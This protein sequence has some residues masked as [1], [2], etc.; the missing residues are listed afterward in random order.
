[1][2]R[3]EN[4]ASDRFSFGWLKTG[5]KKR[6]I[7]GYH[8]ENIDSKQPVVIAVGST[9]VGNVTAP[10]ITV[11][12]QLFGTAVASRV[13]I[14]AQ[15]QVWGDVYAAELN[16]ESGGKL[17]GWFTTIHADGI[18]NLGIDV[19]PQ[20]VIKDGSEENEMIHLTQRDPD[21]IQA[22]RLLQRE[23][24]VAL[25]A[26]AELEQTFDQ[27]V[28]EVIGQA[29]TEVQTLRNK[30]EA[31]Q[32]Q[33]E[34]LESRVAL[35]TLTQHTQEEQLKQQAEEL[36]VARDLLVERQQTIDVLQ[37]N[38]DGVDATNDQFQDQL[39]E[40]RQEL[41][42]SKEEIRKRG[43][44][45]RG[46]ESA[47]QGSLQHTSEQEESLVRWQELAEA[48]ELHVK[49]LEGELDS[50]RLE[51]VERTSRV[52]DWQGELEPDQEMSIF[53]D[54]NA[55][56]IS[57]LA[58]LQEEA[59]E[60]SMQL[61]WYKA[62]LETS[63]LE[64]ESY[65]Q[66]ALGQNKLLT[67]LQTEFDAQ[68]LQT[69]K[70]KTGFEKIARQLQLLKKQKEQKYQILSDK[71]QAAEEGLKKAQ[72]QLNISQTEIEQYQIELETQ[73]QHLAELQNILVE[74]DLKTQQL[75]TQLAKQ[76]TML[77]KQSSVLKQQVHLQKE[78]DEATK[79]QIEIAH[80][81]IRDLKQVIERR[82]KRKI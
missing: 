54:G 26:R 70:W 77:A 43:E 2:T 69:G 30:V 46:L 18:G 63:R 44:R 25:A 71:K 78:K 33:R 58:L 40:Y 53:E 6:E 27:R 39:V 76:S 59:E 7:S 11:N 55:S 35:F 82:N 81:Q 14:Q 62:N 60:K 3:V 75:E 23:T 73:G 10:V 50:L 67:R 15:G 36:D 22:L 45:L 65:E 68:Q 13:Y 5:K 57:E 47:L 49:E 34:E 16:L 38:L 29:S 19:S 17:T 56:L 74:H 79:Q 9:L 20:E 4:K 31:L 21:E 80:Q 72:L 1:M 64:L 41:I 42:D 61:L 32:S 51:L 52:G 37:V 12:G 28:S 8:V 24:A 66:A 48:H